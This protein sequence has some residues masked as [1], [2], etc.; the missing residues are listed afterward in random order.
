MRSLYLTTV[1]AVALTASTAFATTPFDA[2]ERRVGR[3]A[4]GP[5]STAAKVMCACHEPLTGLAGRLVYRRQQSVVQ[6]FCEVPNF[7][8]DGRPQTYNFCNRFVTLSK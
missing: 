7:G 5:L 6:V 2:F 8:P 3:V 1:A 4:A